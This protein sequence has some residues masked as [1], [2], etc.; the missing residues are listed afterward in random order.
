MAKAPHFVIKNNFQKGGRL[1]EDLLTP[2]ILEDLCLRT[3]NRPDFTC[4]FDNEGYNKGKMAILEY[5]GKRIYISFLEGPIR[6]RNASFQSL[7]SA[8]SRYLLD[9]SPRKAMYFYVHPDTTGNFETD[10][11]L[12]M[13]RLMKT[14][15]VSFLN[16]SDHISQQ[17]SAFATP[18]DIIIYKE[19]LRRKG[20]GNNS[21]YITRGP[22]GAVEI[23]GK[24][25]GANKY[26]TT[27]LSVAAA[28]VADSA[29]SLYE[30]EEGGLSALPAMSRAALA[31]LGNVT[32]IPYSDAIEVA[33]FEADDSLRSVR[34]IY[35]LLER[36]GR[37]KCAFC[38]CEIP[39]IIQG[40][41]IWPVASIKQDTSLSLDEKLAHALDGNNGL[42]LCE[43]H[44]KLLDSGTLFLSAD[45]LVKCRR[46]LGSNDRTFVD[47]ITTSKTLP[48]EILQEGFIDYLGRRNVHLDENAF[49]EFA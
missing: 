38:D 29:V 14:A 46:L 8:L 28:R 11:F 15:G 13:Y 18:D 37:K 21:T 32:I 23:Y 40:A 12:F 41:H 2:E 36:L 17:I 25:Y 6:S 5:R 49:L 10:Y 20:K 1:Y 27:L 48:P 30:V 26:E 39:Q 22:T 42:W 47:R 34:F 19:R 33:E 3:T 31:A 7:P 9:P 16:L 43:N 45:G 44:H 24:T 35:N 4:D